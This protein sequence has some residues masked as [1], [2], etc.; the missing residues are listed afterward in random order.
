MEEQALSPSQSDEPG[1]EVAS[2]SPAQQSPYEE[3]EAVGSEAER[4]VDPEAEAKPNSPSQLE[5]DPGEG[6]NTDISTAQ[7]AAEV[8][9]PLISIKTG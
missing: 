7:D 9:P 8:R 4:S 5:S 3:L 6:G 2:R 1:E